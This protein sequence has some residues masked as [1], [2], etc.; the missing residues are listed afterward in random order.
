[1][2]SR[3]QPIR[4]AILSHRFQRNDGQGRVN[5]EV[6]HAALRT[7]YHVT[8]VATT[9][10]EELG[11]H[12]RCRFVKIGN[13]QLPSELLRNLVYAQ[14]S[15]SWL[16]AHR[17]EFDIVKAN[18][19]VTWEP[20]DVVAAHFVHAAWGRSR[21]FPFRNL[22]PYSLYQRLYTVLNTRWE[23]DAFTRAKRV[24]AVA[25]PL[26]HELVEI[27]VRADNIDVVWNGVDTKQFHPGASHR[28]S[29]GLSPEATVALF[30]G[31]IRTPR[32][33]LDTVLRAMRQVPD[34]SLVVA[35]AVQRSPYPKLARE[36][37]VDERVHFLGQVKTID[38]LMRSVDMFVFPSRY[39]AHPLV[40][41]EA[42]ASGLPSI[43]SGTFGAGEFMGGGG[44]ILDDP[45]DDDAL[46]HCMRILAADPAV[47]SSMGAAGRRRALEMDWSTMADQ[48]L[49]I[50]EDIIE[51]EH[52]TRVGV[53]A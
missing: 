15:A 24:I 48:Y 32:K 27:G 13:E 6:A 5:F 51:Q 37:G 4:L 45:D 8:I 41:L 30:V 2:H 50:F 31:D 20:C 40:L 39:E 46:A 11:S 10:S 33:N 29:F 28:Q 17:H 16:R 47:R 3:S 21:W 19:F 52:P 12:P 9:C 34:L 49:R 44:F 14:G 35:G 18:G 43:V 36:L 42:M 23:K 25:R 26:V 22:R 53:M 1:M 38:L 7:G